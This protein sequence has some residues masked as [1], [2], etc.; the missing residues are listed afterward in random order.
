[1]DQLA[2]TKKATVRFLFRQRRRPYGSSSQHS[3]SQPTLHHQCVAA[4]KR[5][6][7]MRLAE[8]A[9][10]RSSLDL[11]GPFMLLLV[12]K[13]LA[14]CPEALRWSEAEQAIAVDLTRLVC[15]PTDNR[16]LIDTL[17]DAGFEVRGRT[18]FGPWYSVRIEYGSLAICVQGLSVDTAADADAA[19]D[20]E[21]EHA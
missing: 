9:A 1:M 11:L 2:P 8:L 5:S 21:A 16:R 7:A 17:C 18:E 15:D 3:Q 19:D 10:M 20:L 13:R 4:A 14:L 12:D 6:H